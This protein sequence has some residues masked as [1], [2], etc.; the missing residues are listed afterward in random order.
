MDDTQTISELFARDPFTL[1]KEDIDKM[2][3]YYR[4][5]RKD[6]V[7]GGKASPKIEKPKVDLNDLGL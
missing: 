1:T 2:I 7:L 3:E 5:R 6:F 4:D